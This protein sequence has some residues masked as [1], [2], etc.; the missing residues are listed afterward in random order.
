MKSFIYT[1]HLY[2]YEKLTYT[3]NLYTYFSLYLL[4]LEHTA[5]LA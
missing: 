4:M 3:S 5:N 1:L 2:S